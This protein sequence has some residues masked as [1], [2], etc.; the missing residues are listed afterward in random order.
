M[1]LLRSKCSQTTKSHAPST[2]AKGHSYSNGQSELLMGKAIKRFG[3]KRGDL[4]ISTKVNFGDGTGDNIVNR[5][6]LSRKHIIEGTLA[7]LERLQLD[8]VDI[9]FAHRPDR[10]T[11]MEE[12]VKAFNYVID[13]GLAFYWGTSMWGTDELAEACTVAK[14]L[15]LAGPVVE[16][17]QYN[18]IDR[19]KVEGEY[20]R[21]CSKFGIGLTVYSPLKQ[22]ILTG[23]YNNALSSPPADT[24]FSQ[25][26]DR[27]KKEKYGSENWLL[28]IEQVRKVQVCHHNSHA[29]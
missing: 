1:T 13:K 24:R 15:G 14:S 21:V 2:Q 26:E 18:M 5:H 9:I 16:Q 19:E 29:L 27:A 10:Q 22:G 28:N 20:S 3:W 25:R 7:S 4:V 8:Y 23:K 6:G 11:P 17:P 12:I